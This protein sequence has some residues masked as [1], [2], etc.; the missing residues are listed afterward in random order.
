MQLENGKWIIGKGTKGCRHCGTI[1][2][3]HAANRKAIWYHPGVQCC[4][5]SLE[6]QLRWRRNDLEHQRN[7]YRQAQNLVADLEAKAS[8]AV[9][10]ERA[11]F[12]NEA[13]KARE[14]L[15]IKERRLRL[16][17]DGDPINEVLGLKAEIAALEQQMRN[18]RGA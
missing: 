6:D 15:P 8:R 2:A 13:N 1:E 17:V 7:A 12:N 14:A 4:Q 9:G 11:T 18:W 16:I 10:A 3:H 5:K